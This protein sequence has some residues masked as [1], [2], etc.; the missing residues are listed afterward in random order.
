MC[1]P[2]LYDVPEKLHRLT[3]RGSEIGYAG[4]CIAPLV[5]SLN[6]GGFQTV[7]S[8]CGHGKTKGVVSSST[9][10]ESSPCYC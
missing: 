9:D 10:L 7:V 1:D 8:C 4:P 5:Q 6:N 2:T 3:S